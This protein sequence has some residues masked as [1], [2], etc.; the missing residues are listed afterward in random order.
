MKYFKKLLIYFQTPS[1]KAQ[2][3]YHLNRKLTQSRFIYYV[4]K[5]WNCI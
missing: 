3:Y 4:R 2:L 1:S 5:Y